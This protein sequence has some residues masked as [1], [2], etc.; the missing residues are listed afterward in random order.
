VAQ[1][2]LIT[3]LFRGFEYGGL[4]RIQSEHW[5]WLVDISPV[6]GGPI[7]WA[8][9][10][11]CCLLVALGVVVRPSIVILLIFYAQLGHLY[12]PGD[13]GIDRM[14]RTVLLIL[15]FSGCHR[16]FGLGGGERPERIPAWPAQLITFGLVLMYMGAG[17]HKLGTNPQWLAVSGDVPL[18]RILCDPMAGRIDPGWAVDLMGLWRV[19]GWLTIVFEVGALVLL[20]RLGRWWALMGLFMHLGLAMTMHLGMFSWAML[21]FYPVLLGPWTCSAL[22]WL[23]IHSKEW[24]QR[25]R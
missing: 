25:L 14:I 16:A 4:S 23:G 8:L 3:T 15:L 11:L 12:P 20:S 19:L 24:R 18:F 17:L 22:D 7:A 2:G 10:V 1:E 5:L 9:C 13:R 6:W 21:A